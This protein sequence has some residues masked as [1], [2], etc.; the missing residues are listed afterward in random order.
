MKEMKENIIIGR[1]I[2]AWKQYRKLKREWKLIDWDDEYFD[3]SDEWV[4][5]S[6]EH[7]EEVIHE[8]EH[9]SDF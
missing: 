7:L 3:A 5:V 6:E 1:L 9:E 4:D 8:I 2:P